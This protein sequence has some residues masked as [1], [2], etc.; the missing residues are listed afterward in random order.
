MWFPWFALALTSGIAPSEYNVRYCRCTVTEKDG[1][2]A[3]PIEGSVGLESVDP[4][5]PFNYSPS[6][7]SRD[8]NQ[9]WFGSVVK[10]LLQNFGESILSRRQPGTVV[11]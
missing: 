11:F 10:G 4:S 5:V 9:T 6:T 8:C 7:A 1:L 2:S 3:V